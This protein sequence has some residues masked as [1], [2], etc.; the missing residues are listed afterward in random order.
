VNLS[1]QL[2]EF[3][4]GAGVRQVYGIT[5]DALNYFVKGIEKKEGMEW[6]AMRYE[7]NAAFA[8][9]TQA[10]LKGLGICAGTVGPG[11]LHL[12]NGLYS[13]KRERLPVIAVTGQIERAR[14]GR[15][16]FQDAELE[17]AFED[18]CAYQA[19][20]REPKEA[21]FLFKRAIHTAIAH[22]AI[23]RIELPRDLGDA[24][25]PDVGA[26]IF[27]N[28][29]IL[30][31]D[32]AY[33][34]KAAEIINQHQNITILAGHG[35][36]GAEEE[37]IAL[38]KSIQAPIVHTL[39]SADI[40]HHHMDE[41]VG[42]TGLIGVPSAY[43]AIM[44]CGLLIMLGTDFPYDD[45]LPADKPVMQIDLKLENLG[46]RVPLL[47]GIQGDVKHTL[48][49]TLPFIEHKNETG[50]LK[51]YRSKFIQWKAEAS[52]AFNAENELLPMHPQIITQALDKTAVRNAFFTLDTSTAVIWAVR[53]M[54]FHDERQIFGSFN[55]GS[56]SVGLA[57]AI[58][59][60]FSSP[61]RQVWALCGDGG[62]SMGM[63]DFIT[64]VRYK[65]PIKVIV[66]NN[67][68][69]QLIN[70]EMENEGD[71]P[72]LEAARL[73]NPDF[74]A[75]AKLCGG[76]GLQI[77]TPSEVLPA[78]EKA[79]NSN[80]PFVIDAKVNGL[81]IPMPPHLSL[82]EV[83]KLTETKLKQIAAGATGD[84]R[85]LNYLIAQLKAMI[86]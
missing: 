71:L 21:H 10:H 49:L 74:A 31:P 69:L 17:K 30:L 53:H 72:N 35:C 65:L 86:K 45:Y 60:Q 25:V 58:G 81:E 4:F 77:S 68:S 14:R 52:E 20:I 12:V 34:R 57:A 79:S 39:R 56:M 26:A 11:A 28:S 8:A 42:L 23:C 3:L 70:L 29:T 19:I 5:G 59:A 76:D 85:Q 73:T 27:S 66:F 84:K 6:V 51:K 15:N 78:L 55:H 83:V 54:S 22:K 47:H 64:A 80:V 1:E 63:Q 7:G 18:V 43:K 32:E 37:V 48:L 40:F 62:F 9:G 46:N 36:K 2:V 33:T 13:A 44:D 41:V 61:G 24:H 16:Y 82:K 50:F 67:A 75:Y 38:A